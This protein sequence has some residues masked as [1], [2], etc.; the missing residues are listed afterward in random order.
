MTSQLNEISET[1]KSRRKELNIS[2]KEV[3][4]ATS[5]R[6]NYLQAIEDG[7]MTKL[8]SPVY[9]QGFVK[10]YAAF[11]GF[12][13]EQL[14][15]EHIEM[16]QKPAASEFDYGIGTLEKRGGHIGSVKGVPN[17]VWIGAFLLLFALAYFTAKMLDLV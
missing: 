3:E 1:L 10:Q 13:G 15:R 5:I 14:I 6:M 7:E 17:I 16:F 12:D 2:L 8:I 9:A 4:T 11:L